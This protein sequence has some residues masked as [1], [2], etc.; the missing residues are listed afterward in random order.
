LDIEVIFYIFIL[1][2]LYKHDHVGPVMKIEILTRFAEEGSYYKIQ[3][4]DFDKLSN[5]VAFPREVFAYIDDV[6]IAFPR[7]DYYD[8][9]Q[10]YIDYKNITGT[11]V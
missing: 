8:A 6:R 2:K 3:S 7:E 5:I 1:Y 4:I 9:V 11:P 10:R